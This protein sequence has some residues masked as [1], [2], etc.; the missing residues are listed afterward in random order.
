MADD[1]HALSAEAVLRRLDASHLGLSSEEARKRLAR[2]GPKVLYVKGAQERILA[3]CTSHVVDGQ[4]VRYVGVRPNS[5]R[6]KGV[7][8]RQVRF[9]PLV[10]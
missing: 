3:A 5:A 8:L 4:V 9:P 6:P 2:V 7:G 1:W 10:G